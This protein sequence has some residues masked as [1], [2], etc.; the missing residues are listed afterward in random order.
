MNNGLKYLRE[1]LKWA[2]A[3]AM[4]F[5]YSML[6]LLIISFLFLSVI[7]ITIKTMIY[8]SVGVAVVTAIVYPCIGLIKKNR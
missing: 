6:I 1:L 5:I 8:I 4:A 7:H 3:V 2:L